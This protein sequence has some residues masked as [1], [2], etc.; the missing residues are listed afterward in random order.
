MAPLEFAVPKSFEEFFD[1]GC[2][3][4]T[5]LLVV[6]AMN[7]ELISGVYEP[8][9][10]Q[11]CKAYPVSYFSLEKWHEEKSLWGRILLEVAYLGGSL[12][13]FDLGHCFFLLG[14][15]IL[16]VRWMANFR[17]ASSIQICHISFDHVPKS[18]TLRPRQTLG[19]KRVVMASS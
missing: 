19:S 1:Y 2:S 9:F 10:E 12:C 14:D 11:L 6:S 15:A 3:L 17:V 16:E 7:Y 8:S 18:S 5:L 4:L 13:I